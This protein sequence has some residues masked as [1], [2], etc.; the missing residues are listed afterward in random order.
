M[1]YQLPES[2]QYFQQNRMALDFQMDKGL[3]FI[4]AAMHAADTRIT[5]SRGGETVRSAS[6]VE[7]GSAF[8]KS[9]NFF[10]NADGCRELLREHYHDVRTCKDKDDFE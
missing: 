7:T 1:V 2:K 10:G 3:S 8:R 4:P 5:F 9:I 6:L